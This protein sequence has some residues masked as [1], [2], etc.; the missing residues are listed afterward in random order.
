ME[1][2]GSKGRLRIRCPTDPPKYSGEDNDGSVPNQSVYLV[3]LVQLD[4]K[5]FFDAQ[6]LE[7]TVH[8]TRV[9]RFELDESVIPTH[10]IGRL[11]IERDFLRFALIDWDW[12]RKR[13]DK[14]IAVYG[15]ITADD[16]TLRKFLVTHADDQE[17]FAQVV[18]A[19]QEWTVP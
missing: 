4:G 16:D 3:S 5:L 12:I 11:W 1:V 8:G 2:Y 7:Q 17:V 6:F 14:S 18:S 19:V 9:E 10:L 13:A 15:V